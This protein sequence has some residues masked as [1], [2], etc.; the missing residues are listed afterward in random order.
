[1]VNPTDSLSNKKYKSAAKIFISNF[2]T[3][4]NACSLA[5]LA[6]FNRLFSHKHD[7]SVTRYGEI[8]ALW[9]FF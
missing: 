1:M 5:F 8:P 2:G 7:A 6:Y 9:Q 4:C 3:F